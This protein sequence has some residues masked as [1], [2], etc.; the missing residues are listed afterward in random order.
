MGGGGRGWISYPGSKNGPVFPAEDMLDPTARVEPRAQGGPR[1]KQRG[2]DA[3]DQRP[4]ARL[5]GVSFVRA[6]AGRPGGGGV[7]HCRLCSGSTRRRGCDQDPA[8]DERQ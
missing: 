5:G 3:G 1:D 4:R 6:S 7:G 8:I 2:D